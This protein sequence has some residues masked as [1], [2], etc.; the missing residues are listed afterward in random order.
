MGRHIA[1]R[2]REGALRL[3][4]GVFT[5]GEDEWWVQRRDGAVVLIPRA[6]D[7][8]KLYLEPTTECPLACR[9]CVRH[10]WQDP[11]SRLGMETY[12]HL[13]AETRAM[14]S[15]KRMVFGGIGEP[16]CHPDL[17]EMIALARERGLAVTLSTNGHLLNE[18]LSAELVRA[19]VDR[20]VVSLDGADPGTYWDVR[21]AAMTAV[22]ENIRYLN[23]AKR[24]LGS[25]LPSLEIEFVA[26]RRNV[27]ELGALARLAGA[28]NASRVLVS[29][30][31]PH[32]EE[33]K[34]ERLY[35]RE[36]A[37]PLRTVSWHVKADAWVL[38][39]MFDLPRMHWGAE[40]RCPFV[41]DRAAVVGW[42]GGIAPCYALSHSYSYFAVDGRPKHVTRHTFGNIT[43]ENLLDIW[44]GEE[45]CRFRSEVASF[46]FPSCPDCD[47]R[48]SCDLRARNE[49]CWGYSPSCA[50]CLYAQDIVRCP[51]GGR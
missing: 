21:G 37:E 24:R 49:A 30:V 50:D 17:T 19:G 18:H 27:G 40:R 29:H 3:P 25:L 34:D 41:Q 38:W 1:A 7:L 20:L 2:M 6:P 10:A 51:G 47:L 22:L 4:E 42:D 48:E 32:T 11:T 33:M 8:S 16:I 28:L 5:S 36:P 9:T 23:E 12:R 14:P 35:G 39:G 15:L 44:T 46:R 26:L 45:Y 43:E 13:L 31:L